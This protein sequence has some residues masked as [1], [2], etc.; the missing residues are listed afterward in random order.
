MVAT[1]GPSVAVVALDMHMEHAGES[2]ARPLRALSRVVLAAMV[3]PP[4]LLRMS[5]AAAAVTCTYGLRDPVDR[6]V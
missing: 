6:T 1:C 2:Y 5:S 3:W 4:Q